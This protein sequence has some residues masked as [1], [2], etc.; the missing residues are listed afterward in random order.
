MS[1]RNEVL[2]QSPREP[3]SAMEGWLYK[4][5]EKGIVKKW[6]KR[7][8]EAHNGALTYA[9]A[10]DAPPLGTV[11]LA[12]VKLIERGAKGTFAVH[13]PGRVY[14][15]A[16]LEDA[17]AAAVERWVA[18]LQLQCP[19]ARVVDDLRGAATT[20]AAKGGGASPRGGLTVSGHTLFRSAAQTDA[21]LDSNVAILPATVSGGTATQSQRP[22]LPAFAAPPLGASPPAADDDLVVVRAVTPP[23][24]AQPVPTA[25]ARQAPVR[26]SMIV[27]PSS[28]MPSSAPPPPPIVPEDDANRKRAQVC[29]EI[30]Q[31]ELAYADQLEK[32]ASCYQ[33]PL[34]LAGVLD[35]ESNRKIFSNLDVLLRL[36]TELVA[37]LQ[38]RTGGAAQPVDSAFPVGELLSS[39]SPA[40]T[41]YVDFVNGFGSAS[42]LLRELNETKRSFAR[43]LAKLTHGKQA[44]LYALET[45][46]VVPVQR[47]PRYVL[48][49]KEVLRHT[50]ETHG[51]Y[52]AC[53]KALA[54]MERI[55]NL[56]NEKKREFENAQRIAYISQR[57]GPGNGLMEPHRKIIFEATM[58]V[59]LSRMDRAAEYESIPFFL[60]RVLLCNDSMILLRVENEDTDAERVFLVDHMRWGSASE[61]AV[62]DDS[63][64]GDVFSVGHRRDKQLHLLRAPSADD[65]SAWVASFR[66]AMASWREQGSLQE[67]RDRLIARRLLGV[68]VRITGSVKL[69]PPQQQKGFRVFIIELSGIVGAPL[70]IL[71]RHHQIKVLHQRLLSRFGEA[72]I[73]L[74][75]FPPSKRMQNK[76]TARTR[77]DSAYNSRW[78]A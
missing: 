61:G 18:V 50:P 65:K 70:Q 66:A 13:V 29:Q 54:Q 17:G 60:R 30:V 73:G 74:P 34:L 52:A 77:A 7:Y 19:G 21:G 63:A 16:V 24:S 55:G 72:H 39:I 1:P 9:E 42:T 2:S 8:F 27:T 6:R 43:A 31:S 47:V 67:Q 71:K 15:L 28:A 32:L 36:H 25:K 37:L 26:M 58:E 10:K 12:T 33:Q 53:N 68:Q 78:A 22:R 20:P 76:S 51:D 5:G 57:L 64:G 62:L 38:S 45:L 75:K 4:K 35:A 14:E 59:K 46:L 23:A 49:M 69:A 48:L 56:I 3:V 40:L 41:L 11:D 44:G